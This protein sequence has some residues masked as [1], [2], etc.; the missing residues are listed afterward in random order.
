MALSLLA[1][2]SLAHL[3]CTAAPGVCCSAL[4]HIRSLFVEARTRRSSKRTESSTQPRPGVLT[5]AAHISGSAVSSAADWVIK[6]RQDP[7]TWQ[8]TQRAYIHTDMRIPRSNPRRAGKMPWRDSFDHYRNAAWSM[9]LN[10]EELGP[11]DARCVSQKTCMSR[12]V[13]MPS[14]PAATPAAS[15]AAAQYPTRQTIIPRRMPMHHSMLVGK[16]YT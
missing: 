13:L 7:S 10:M 6:S 12:L 16:K 14:T 3:A 5:Q 1:S 4:P 8:E 2:R 15:A 11:L 9:L